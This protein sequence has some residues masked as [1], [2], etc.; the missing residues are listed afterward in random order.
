MISENKKEKRSGT[1][2]ITSAG[3]TGSPRIIEIN[4]NIAE[5]EVTIL[6]NLNVAGIIF[7]SGKCK[8]ICK[9]SLWLYVF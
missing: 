7:G 3:T 4:Q 9:K 2:T 1:I 6:I 8:S 5:Y